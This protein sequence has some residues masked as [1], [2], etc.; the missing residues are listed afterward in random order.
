MCNTASATLYVQHCMCTIARALCMYNTAC[1]TLHVQHC[2][3]TIAYAP[4]HVHHCCMRTLMC[5]H[6]LKRKEQV[7]L[8]GCHIANNSVWLWVSRHRK[9]SLWGTAGGALPPFTPTVTALTPWEYKM[10][11]AARVKPGTSL[12]NTATACIDA[13]VPCGQQEEYIIALQPFPASQRKS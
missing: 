12:C 7:L 1:A 9:G 13:C 8:P 4:L 3:C 6:Q 11:N 5:I 10:G 2:M